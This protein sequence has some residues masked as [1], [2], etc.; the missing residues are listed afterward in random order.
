MTLNISNL[1]IITFIKTLGYLPEK[2]THVRFFS[3]LII[4]QINILILNFNNFKCFAHF[5]LI[6]VLKLFHNI[7]KSL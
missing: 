6:Y 4:C 5:L 2:N 3:M 7:F 1:K